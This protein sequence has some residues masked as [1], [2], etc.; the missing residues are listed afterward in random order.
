MSRN[1]TGRHDN[2]N[3]TLA[4]HAGKKHEA[5]NYIRSLKKANKRCNCLFC[6]HEKGT[7]WVEVGM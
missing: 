6:F 1:L 5:V 4:L 3:M 2:A 7:T